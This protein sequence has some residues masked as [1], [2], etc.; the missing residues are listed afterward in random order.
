[1]GGATAC[2]VVLP[3]EGRDVE[4]REASLVEYEMPGSDRRGRVG[5]NAGGKLDGPLRRISEGWERLSWEITTCHS[6]VGC[7]DG[8]GHQQPVRSA[9]QR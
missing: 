8:G 6:I 5:G 2:R 7:R 1:M 9:R 3:K 4:L